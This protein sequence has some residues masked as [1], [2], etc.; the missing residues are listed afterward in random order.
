MTDNQPLLLPSGKPH[1]RCAVPLLSSSCCSSALSPVARVHHHRPKARLKR[2]ILSA[3]YSENLPSPPPPPAAPPGRGDIEQL[4][5]SPINQLRLRAREEASPIS[6]ILAAHLRPS[7]R[8]LRISQELKKMVG[9]G[10]SE[11]KQKQLEKCRSSVSSSTD[12]R[13]AGGLLHDGRHHLLHS[14]NNLASPQLHSPTGSIAQLDA[15]RSVAAETSRGQLK[16]QQQQC[17]C[18]PKR[19][20]EEE[21]GAGAEAREG[22]GASGGGGGGGKVQLEQVRVRVAGRGQTKR[23]FPLIQFKRKLQSKP[24]FAV[25]SNL[26][27]FLDHQKQM[28][29]QLT[30]T[31]PPPDRSYALALTPL[32]ARGKTLNLP[33]S[34]SSEAPGPGRTCS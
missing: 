9:A 12:R 22:L 18:P 2:A 16:Q 7:N 28:T 24:K 26:P 19:C 34:S 1:L 10:A 21:E 6:S 13:G 20:E 4:L 25:D 31:R 27:R 29:R 33:P 5:A 15:L 30:L 11:Q 14:I 3:D 23:R 8:A 32:F 17:H